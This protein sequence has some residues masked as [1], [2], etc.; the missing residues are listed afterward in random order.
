M[1]ET[2]AGDGVERGDRLIQ[3]QEGGTLRQAHREGDLGLLA[4]RE[5]PDLR[6]GRNLEG[7]EV[8]AGGGGVPVRIE[9]FAKAQ[10]LVDAKRAVEGTLL[11]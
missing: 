2:L 1:H 9:L 3:Q 4:H 7:V 6:G 5:L 8:T 10:H 11:V